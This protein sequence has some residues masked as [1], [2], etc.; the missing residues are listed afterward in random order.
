MYPFDILPRPD[1]YFD[2]VNQ[3]VPFSHWRDKGVNHPDWPPCASDAIFLFG[4]KLSLIVWQWVRN[5]MS[6]C[7][8]SSCESSY[9]ENLWL[10]NIQ[11]ANCP[12]TRSF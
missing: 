9:M 6:Q 5:V 3:F 11:H 4:C 1:F 12:V 7:K 8:S 10:Q 2:G